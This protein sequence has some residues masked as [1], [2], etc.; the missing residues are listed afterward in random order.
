MEGHARG[1]SWGSCT[2]LFYCLPLF[3][4]A[5]CVL[6]T[7]PERPSVRMSQMHDVQALTGAGGS[8]LASAAREWHSCLPVRAA[9]RG[10]GLSPR[11]FLPAC[12]TVLASSPFLGP[13]FL[14]LGRPSFLCL[15]LGGEPTAVVAMLAV[16][17]L[18][19]APATHPGRR[20]L[21]FSQLQWG[22]RGLAQGYVTIV[23]CGFDLS[24]WAR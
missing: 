20:E 14:P 3:Y 2:A 18:A 12:P 16:V 4:G 24:L 5:R 13:S 22:H 7:F 23:Q 10:Q 9:G 15:H 19:S 21:W 1:D 11:S 8:H 17:A 6:G